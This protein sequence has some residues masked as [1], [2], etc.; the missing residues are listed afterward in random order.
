MFEFK[1][2]LS[3]ECEDFLYNKQR[4]LELI[5]CGVGA[6]VFSIVII[7]FAILVNP[8]LFW[9]LILPLLFVIA[10]ILPTTKKGFLQRMPN[11]IL[12]DFEKDTIFYQSEKSKDT[13]R[14]SQIEKIFDHGNFYHIIFEPVPDSYYVLQKDLMIQ[15]TISEFEE[16]FNDK[17]NVVETY[18]NN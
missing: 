2:K 11:R 15:G 3:K 10:P 4:R 6:T 16:C 12:F 14:I 8:I 5:S 18:R 17:I 9:G 1:G 7:V 13:Y